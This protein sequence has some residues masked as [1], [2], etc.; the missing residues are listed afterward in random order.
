VWA[1]FWDTNGS[2]GSIKWSRLLIWPAEHKY[3][4]NDY[5]DF[6]IESDI[7]YY[8]I[9]PLPHLFRGCTRFVYCRS[10]CSSIYR[11][12]ITVSWCLLSVW[13]MERPVRSHPIQQITVLGFQFVWS[14]PCRFLCSF[15]FKTALSNHGECIGYTPWVDRLQ[16]LIGFLL[17]PGSHQLYDSRFINMGAGSHI[18]F[19]GGPGWV[20]RLSLRW[21]CRFILCCNTLKTEAVFSCE[22]LVSKSTRR[23]NTENQQRWN[24]DCVVALACGKH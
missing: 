15:S 13:W 19:T 20:L 12:I 9:K 18:Q 24:N 7:N 1:N 5:K 23:Y 14:Q 8:P 4:W 2:S 17:S 3:K 6:G 10:I 22:T 21:I 11:S 16:A